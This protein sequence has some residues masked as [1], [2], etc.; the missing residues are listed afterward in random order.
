[1]NFYLA[2]PGADWNHKSSKKMGILQKNK[3]Y[4]TGPITSYKQGE[5][6]LCIGPYNSSYPFIF[7]HLQGL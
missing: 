4:K 1:M 2:F 7:G 6:I 3:C 5:I